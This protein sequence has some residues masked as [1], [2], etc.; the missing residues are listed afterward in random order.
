MAFLGF[1]QW[2]SRATLDSDATEVVTWWIAAEYSRYHLA[3]TDV[4][5][6]ERAQFLLAT[7][8]VQLASISARG[9]P[10]RM[11][12]RVEVTP[13]TASPPGWDGVRYYRMK[14]ST[15]TGW[16]MERETTAVSYYLA[17]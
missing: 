15:I 9:R 1:R 14:Y 16:H 13:G 11:F 6:Q 12:V 4:T 17:L 8:S 5:D 2:Q 3:R 7:D 10:A